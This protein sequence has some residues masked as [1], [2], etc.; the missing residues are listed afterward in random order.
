[1]MQYYPQ[2]VSVMGWVLLAGGVVI[3]L[4]ALQFITKGQSALGNDG[5]LHYFLAFCGSVNVVWA[6]IL[7]AAAGDPAL[8]VKIALPC[9]VGFALLSLWRIPLCRHPDVLAK[10][11][12]APMAEVFFFAVIAGV[13]VMAGVA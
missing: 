13:F 5:V 4:P 9:A 7:L 1:M 3:S 10:L 6:L 11:G 12:K 2:F 8:A